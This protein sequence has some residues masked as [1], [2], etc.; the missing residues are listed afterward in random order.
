MCLATLVVTAV[1]H[2]R[3][4]RL[5]IIS[6]ARG[7]V[8][9]DMLTRLNV[10]TLPLASAACDCSADSNCERVTCRYLLRLSPL[11]LLLP[12]LRLPEVAH[13]AASVSLHDA[14]P[15]LMFSWIFWTVGDVARSSDRRM[16]VLVLWELTETLGSGRGLSSLTGFDS[17]ELRAIRITM[18]EKL[19]P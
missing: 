5:D 12:A 16:E 19:I 1:G 7:S 6:I 2:S 3:L 14:S 15:R 11:L 8:S 18:R 10:S 9:L 4:T 13:C 17:A